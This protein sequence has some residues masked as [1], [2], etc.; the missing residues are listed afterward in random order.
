MKLALINNIIRYLNDE[1]QLL[2]S[3]ANNAHQAAIDDQ[4]I[5]ETQYDTLAIEAGYLAEGQS[6]RVESLKQA[7]ISFEQLFEILKQRPAP[8]TSIKLGSIVQLAQ[9]QTIGQY[10]FIAPAAAGYR[11]EVAGKKFTVITPESPMG[12]SLINQRLSDEVSITLGN[13]I[14]IDE[15]THLS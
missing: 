8:H 11:C 13:T 2:L 4:S 14:H 6:R 15:I 5:A 10:L 7:I 9:E 1:L 12:Q 3:A